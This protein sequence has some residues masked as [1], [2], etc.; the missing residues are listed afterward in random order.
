MTRQQCMPGLARRY[1]DGVYKTTD[2]GANWSESGLTDQYVS[3]LA[4]DP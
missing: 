4:I 3:S 1:Q 2:A